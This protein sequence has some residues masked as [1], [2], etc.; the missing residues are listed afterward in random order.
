MDFNRSRAL[1]HYQVDSISQRGADGNIL[2]V[3]DL[4]AVNLFNNITRPESHLVS[5]AAVFDVA[6]GA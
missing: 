5:N 4:A 3:P 6:D 2:P 1:F